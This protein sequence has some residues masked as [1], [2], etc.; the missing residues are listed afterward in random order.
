MNQVQ[1][2]STGIGSRADFALEQKPDTSSSE[3]GRCGCV[4][5]LLRN[6]PPDGLNLL[7]TAGIQVICQSEGMMLDRGFKG[8][9]FERGR[10]ERSEGLKAGERVTR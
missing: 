4:C 7:H 6:V 9:G 2:K 3:T 8:G 5:G 1:E 10:G